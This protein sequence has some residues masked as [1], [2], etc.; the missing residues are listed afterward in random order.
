M[1]LFTVAPEDEDGGEDYGQDKGEPS[2]RGDFGQHGGE[3]SPVEGGKDE[4]NEENNQGVDAPFEEG[5]EGDLDIAFVGSWNIFW[6]ERCLPCR[7]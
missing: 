3:E 5:D 4:K 2:S 1:L 7:S 6:Y